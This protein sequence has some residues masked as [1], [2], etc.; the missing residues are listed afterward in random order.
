LIANAGVLSVDTHNAS[1]DGYELTFAVNQ[2]AHAQLIGD[3]LD[4]FVAPAR[5]VLLGSNTYHQNIF[6]RVLR[7]APADW[8]DPI[9][10]ARPTPPYLP[11]TAKLSGIACS[12]SKSRSSITR[13]NCNVAHRRGSTSRCS[14][15]DSCRVPD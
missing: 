4:S 14:S 11:A 3:L 12:N 1:V 10:L 6:R 8:R 15:G 13:T 2:L 5:V 9:E 7:V